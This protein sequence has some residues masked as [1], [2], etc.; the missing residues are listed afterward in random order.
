MFKNLVGLP[1][2]TASKLKQVN[3]CNGELINPDYK[4]FA[5]SCLI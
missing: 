3:G 1:P 4:I 2:V 5:N